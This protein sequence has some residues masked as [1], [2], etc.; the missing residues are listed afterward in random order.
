MFQTPVLWWPLMI[1]LNSKIKHFGLAGKKNVYGLSHILRHIDYKGL[2]LRCKMTVSNAASLIYLS[3]TNKTLDKFKRERRAI[4]SNNNH[5][6]VES[7]Y[8]KIFIF[9]HMTT[10]PREAIKCQCNFHRDHWKRMSY[11]MTKFLGQKEL[12]VPTEQDSNIAELY[13]I[14]TSFNLMLTL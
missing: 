7:I 8:N 12:M 9:R 6:S 4:S 2:T 10:R 1:S 3:S 11:L 13:I 5:Q 14:K